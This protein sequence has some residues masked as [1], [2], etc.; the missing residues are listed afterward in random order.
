MD[1]TCGNGGF[2]KCKSNIEI[3]IRRFNPRVGQTPFDSVYVLDFYEGM[4]LHGAL[5]YIFKVLDHTIAFRPYKCNKGICMS[6]AISVNRKRQRACT[7]LLKAGDRLII[8]PYDDKK[9]VRD[10]VTVL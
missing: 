1:R 6:C 3:K 10:L 8:E 4:T 2:D 5:E 9:V 7:T